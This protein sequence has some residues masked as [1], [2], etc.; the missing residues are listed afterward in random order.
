MVIHFLDRS[1]DGSR[2]LLQ[3]SGC[4]IAT[5]WEELSVVAEMAIRGIR[6]LCFDCD[7]LSDT[8]IPM[9]RIDDSVTKIIISDDDYDPRVVITSDGVSASP[10]CPVVHIS[11]LVGKVGYGDE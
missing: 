8:P 7:P 1:Y 3:C 5:D 4:G 9:L 6:N 11:R 2:V 10:P